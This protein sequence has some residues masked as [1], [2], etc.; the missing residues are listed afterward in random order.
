MTR[1]ES[2]IIDELR[3]NNMKSCS[4]IINSE[5]LM[6]REKVVRCEINRS[7]GSQSLRFYVLKDVRDE[8]GETQVLPTGAV[9]LVNRLNS[10][11]LY[12]MTLPV[13]IN[14]DAFRVRMV[15]ALKAVVLES[16]LYTQIL[17]IANKEIEELRKGKQ[18]NYESIVIPSTREITAIQFGEF[19]HNFWEKS[20]KVYK[21]LIYQS[22]KEADSKF[23]QQLYSR[24]KFYKIMYAF[25]PVF[26]DC[27][28]FFNPLKH[29]D[30]INTRMYD[31]AVNA[32][33]FVELEHTGYTLSCYF[34]T[35]DEICKAFNISRYM[36]FTSKFW[37]DIFVG[38]VYPNDSSDFPSITKKVMRGPKA[39]PNYGIPRI[40]SIDD[41]QS[42][43][44]STQTA[45]DLNATVKHNGVVSSGEELM[46]VLQSYSEIDSLW[47]ECENSTRRITHMGS[48]VL[49]ERQ[50]TLADATQKIYDI[51][52]EAQL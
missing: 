38:L 28:I 31:I 4:I 37:Y 44:N 8:H 35:Q 2:V 27:N 16:Q 5:Y 45:I 49:D 20:R 10:T 34:V 14:R 24:N 21:N 11:E 3:S 13:V 17:N 32:G 40:M 50:G 19:M 42:L 26:I 51:M 15:P 33:R 30:F 12:G 18:F 36:R 7:S 43:V 6:F 23:V 25:V 1:L 52:L 47:L 46:G 41:F 48:Y 39:A 9:D 29:P 22:S